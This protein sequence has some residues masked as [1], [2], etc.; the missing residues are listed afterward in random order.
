MAQTP[1]QVLY[2]DIGGVLGTN[3]WDARLRHE[4]CE[5]FDIES[6][7]IDAR[8]HLVFDSYERGYFSFEDYL[9]YVFFSESRDFTLEQVREYTYNASTPWFENIEFLKSVKR[10]NRFRLGLIS[11]EGRGLT[12]HRISKFGLLELA[13]FMVVSHFVHYRK[14]D[15]EIWRL[16]LNLINASP[17]ASIYID[18]R[19]M[20]VNVA[21]EL[22]FTAIQ[23][24][25]LEAT[26]R[27]LLNLAVSL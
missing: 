1:F 9:R 22:G 3:G 20:F 26:R 5:H 24:T 17:A 21:A 12:E 18:D 14:P 27:S 15:P 16:A 23:H 7:P 4:V 25:S 6:E 2:C 19:E 13:D 11:N 8:H 10:A